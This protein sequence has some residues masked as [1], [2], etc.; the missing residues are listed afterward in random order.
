MSEILN[1]YK[2]QKQRLLLNTQ[3]YLDFVLSLDD[4]KTIALDGNLTEKCLISYIDTNKE[5]CIDNAS[6]VS[7]SGYTYE[8]SI[9]D[10]ETLKD[11]GFTNVDNG[12]ISYNKDEITLDDFVNIIQNISYTLPE[13]DNRLHLYP[14]NKCHNVIIKFTISSSYNLF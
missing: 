9:N 2:K 11:L 4:S 14:V 5:E 7:M 1:K 12:H 8:N 3:K 6:L 13:N 10:G